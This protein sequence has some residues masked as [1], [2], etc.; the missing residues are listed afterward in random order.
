MT[1]AEILQAFDSIRVWQRGDQRA[2][3]KPLL[4]LLELGRLARG[5]PA[6][7]SFD[8]IEPD[9]IRLLREFG[10]SGSER[11]RH[12]PFWHLQSDG[13][14]Q[15]QGPQDLLIRPVG[16]TPNIGELRGRA[17]AQLVPQIRQPLS[18]DSDLRNEVALRIVNAHFPESIQRDVLDAVGLDIDLTDYSLKREEQR[19]RD[20]AF[21]R[22]VLL[23]YEYR[24]CLCGYDIRLDDLV[25]GL[26]A[27]HIKWFQAGGPDIES[28]GLAL[29]ALHH[30]IFDL[31]AFTVEPETLEVQFSQHM[32]GS[33]EVQGL[34]LSYHG[35]SLLL[36]QSPQYKPNP[37]YLEWH[38]RQVFKQ[39]ART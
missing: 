24:C 1:R 15:L 7:V 31:G 5:E 19:R 25:I 10:P 2:P 29:C 23:A 11:S 6:A 28:N 38:Q 16:A 34:L 4:I 8:T 26:E 30:K 13:I 35:T 39:P 3:H 37:E 18:R 36:P 21:R 17:S 20:P 9:L 27:A 33:P 22:K 12:Y 14:W 32:L